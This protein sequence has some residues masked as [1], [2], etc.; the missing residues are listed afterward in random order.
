MAKSRKE[1]EAIVANLTEMFRDMKAAAFSSISG[2]TMAQSDELRV[3]AAEQNVKVMIAKK[4]LI[5]AAAKEVGLDID[6]ASY[7]GSILT[8]VS[9]GDEVAAAKLLKDFEKKNEAFKLVAGILEGKGLSA[10]EVSKLASL[11]SKEQLLSQLVGSLNAPIS[12]FVNVLAG[13]LRGLVTVLDAIK[14]Q[15]TA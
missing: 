4:T 3:T 6:P 14:E 1:K 8:A 13:N 15:K 9:F 7:E 12:G 5:A 2:Y 11:P 10:E